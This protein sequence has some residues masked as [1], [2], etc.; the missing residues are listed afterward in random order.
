M[1]RRQRLAG[2]SLPVLLTLVAGS[3]VFADDEL[4]KTLLAVIQ[5]QAD[6][7]NR[8]ATDDA[9]KTIHPQ[10]PMYQQNAKVLR[11]MGSA[12]KL[13]MQVSD[14][15]LIGVDGDYA[16]ARCS[17]KATKV[18]GADYPDNVRDVLEVFRK[19]DGTWKEWVGVTLS[20]RFL[21]TEPKK[22]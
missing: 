3:S 4:A 15:K 8:G 21:D 13:R 5:A 19:E 10:S 6:A 20:T 11:D 2:Y 17:E 1:R 16:F 12:F 7:L 14:F 9:L 18:S 22:P